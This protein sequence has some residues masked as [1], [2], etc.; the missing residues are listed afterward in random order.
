MTE[1]EYYSCPKGGQL[2]GLTYIIGVGAIW[3]GSS[4]LTQYI[5][6]DLDF[7]SPFLV[8][9]VENSLFMIYLPLWQVFHYFRWID[10]DMNGTYQEKTHDILQD[11]CDNHLDDGE[12]TGGEI[13]DESTLEIE[14]SNSYNLSLDESIV[15]PICNEFP[16]EH[17]EA[18]R[19]AL[20]MFPFWFL[21]NCLY[22]YSLLLTSVGSSTI[23]SNL[24]GIFT[25][26]FSYLL[27]LED[28]TTVKVSRI[29][30]NIN[31]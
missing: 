9:F 21:A 12:S 20:I 1:S 26:L 23:I 29:L 14:I 15:N 22:K 18:F 11:F 8:T 27:K 16:R 30:I 13:S 2:L 19:V 3:A 4:V 31:K 25:L 28:I 17:K 6:N 7:R 10:E 24:S 5:F